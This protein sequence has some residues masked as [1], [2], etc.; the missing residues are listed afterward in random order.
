VPVKSTL[1]VNGERIKHTVPAYTIQVIEL[2]R[3]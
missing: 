1:A 3:K 2:D